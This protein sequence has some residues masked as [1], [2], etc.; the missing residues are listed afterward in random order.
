[1]FYTLLSFQSVP[2]WVTEDQ[3]GGLL[4]W[5]VSVTQFYGVG[6]SRS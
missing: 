4:G 2:H 5:L 1:M 6:N 3:W